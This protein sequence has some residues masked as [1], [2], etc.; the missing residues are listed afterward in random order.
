MTPQGTHPPLIGVLAVQGDVREHVAVL[1]DL[2]AE[3]I[4]VRRPEEVER[5][6]GL[7]I[8]GGES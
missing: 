1:R 6:D 7:I 8:P 4:T 5:I 2:G 3:V